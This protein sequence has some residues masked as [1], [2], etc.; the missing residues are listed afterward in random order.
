MPT[1]ITTGLTSEA[2]AELRREFGPNRLPE[3][4]ERPRW[5]RLVD[6][7]RNPLFAV[8]GCA[9]LFALLVRDPID[10]GVILVVLTI[11]AV[12]GYIQEGRAESAMLSLRRLLAPTARVRRDGVVIDLAVADIVPGDIILLTAGSRIPADG[13]F[14]ECVATRVDESSLTGESESVHKRTDPHHDTGYMGTTVV[15]GRGVLLVELTGAATELGRVTELVHAAPEED[16]PLQLQLGRLGTRLAA[17]AA[18]AAAVAFVLRLL[19]GWS[20]ADALLGAIAL[21]VA[22]I[23]EGLPAV[24]TV[25]LAVGVHQ[26]AVHKAIVKRLASVETLGSTTVICSDKTGTLTRNQMTVTALY[27]GTTPAAID[28]GTHAEAILPGL[29]CNDASITDEGTIGEPTETALLTLGANQGIDIAHERV[30]WPRIDEVPFD[31]AA[32][33]MAT[34]HQGNRLL[35]CA[36]GAPEAILPR[37]ATIID[38]DGRERPLDDDTIAALGA[39]QEELASEGM[40]V[41]ALASGENDTGAIEDLVLRS[42]VG[43]VDPPRPEAREAIRRCRRAGVAVKMITGDHPTTAASIA[44][45][46][47]LHGRVVS[48]PELE[49]MTDDDLEATID[50]IAVCARVSPEHKV[51]IVRALRANRHVVA[52]TGDGVNDAA[53]LRSAHIGVAMGD[54]GTDVAKDAADIVLTDDNFATIVSAVEH[55]RAIYDNIAKF[56][57]FQLT[58]NLAAIATILT[59]GMTGL[60]VPLT[61]T[62]VLWVNIIADGPPAMSLGV[63]PPA[64]DTMTRGPRD[65]DEQMLDLHKALHLFPAAITMTIGT[66]I[67]LV[68]GGRAWGDAVGLSA[69]FTTFVFFQLANVFNARSAT[70]TVFGRDSFRNRTLWLVVIGMVAVQVVVVTAAPLQKI[71]DTTA[72]SPGQWALCGAV[73]LSVILVEEVR[74]LLARRHGPGQG[75]SPAMAAGSGP[76]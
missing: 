60:P 62:Q 61:T 24:V 76:R 39:I 71:F 44:R 30:T 15:A 35:V 9:A 26:L 43:I 66:L 12:L 5:K 53:A 17:I 34:V 22:A 57:R 64:S 75:V 33:F 18:I 2:A 51:R 29:L 67:V 56:V 72:L 45:A 38:A 59:A 52:M 20:F 46:L 42:L 63:D 25:T 55:G 1:E 8:L 21:A 14:V 54:T 13:T 16:T 28:D 49:A 36:K 7:F 10:A 73:A 68:A 48:G 3:P 70:A 47:D 32:K 19:D 50:S 40:R 31:S 69:S 27:V 4:P 11:N 41:L 23:P 37:C 65:A 6:Q 74:K 58:T